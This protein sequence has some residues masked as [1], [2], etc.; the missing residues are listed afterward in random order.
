MERN[1]LLAIN[2]L[3]VVPFNK[4]NEAV[5]FIALHFVIWVLLYLYCVLM[6]TASNEYL[7]ENKLDGKDFCRGKVTEL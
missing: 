1:L 6:N 4:N 2:T 7:I 5:I 3:F